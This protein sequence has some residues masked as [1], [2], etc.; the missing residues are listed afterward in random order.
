MKSTDK[1]IQPGWHAKAKGLQQVLWEHGFID[2]QNLGRYTVSGNKNTLTGE[3]DRIYSMKRLLSQCLDFAGELTALEELGQQLGLLIDRTPKFHA[4][5]AGEGITFSWACSKGSYRCQPLS[6]KRGRDSFKA[7]VRSVPDTK[8][9]PYN[10]KVARICKKKGSC[11]Y[12]CIL[13]AQP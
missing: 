8:K 4:E 13:H 12:L 10:G 6:K 7:L 1:V 9:C 3:V 5:M 11:L 2:M